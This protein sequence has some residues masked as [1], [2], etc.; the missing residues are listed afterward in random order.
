MYSSLMQTWSLNCT[1][2]INYTLIFL[3][4]TFPQDLQKGLSAPASSHTKR[5]LAS[6]Y[7]FEFGTQ[8]S[9]HS[10]G[11]I[12]PWKHKVCIRTRIT[13]FLFRIFNFFVEFSKTAK[14]SNNFIVVSFFN[15][16]SSTPHSCRMK[17]TKVVSLM[18]GKNLSIR[19]IVKW[20]WLYASVEFLHLNNGKFS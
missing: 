16:Y 2:H 5:K 14:N 9:F 1:Y 8:K 10:K 15:I 7:S 3:R 11:S 17:D 18:M 6:Q 12:S 19:Q 13:L 20:I 4:C